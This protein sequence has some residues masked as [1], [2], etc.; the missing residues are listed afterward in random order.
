MLF[1]GGLQTVGLEGGSGLR[2]NVLLG[3]K[4]ESTLLGLV[5]QT[6][7]IGRGSKTDSDRH[8]LKG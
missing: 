7:P 8:V 4:G 5:E 1:C 2:V 6:V 3:R